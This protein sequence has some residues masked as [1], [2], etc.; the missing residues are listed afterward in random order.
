MID[1]SSTPLL[2]LTVMENLEL[3][4]MASVYTPADRARRLEYLIGQFHLESLRAKLPRELSSGQMRMV[5]IACGMAK[6]PD[7]LLLDN[8]LDDVSPAE[9]ERFLSQLRALARGHLILLSAPYPLLSPHAGDRLIEFRRNAVISDSCPQCLHAVIGTRPEN[10]HSC[11]PVS[12]ALL[13][14]LTVVLLRERRRAPTVRALCGMGFSDDVLRS[15]ALL[16]R[17]VPLLVF[18]VFIILY[19]LI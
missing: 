17:G 9:R 18:A 5:S 2:H 1:K 4:L 7:I 11:Q 12:F 6:D 14:R 13:C 8:I 16:C 15:A 19:V 10:T 3:A